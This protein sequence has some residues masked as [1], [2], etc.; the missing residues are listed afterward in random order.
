MCGHLYTQVPI[1][2]VFWPAT[3]EEHL[4]LSR[5]TKGVSAVTH[6]LLSQMQELLLGLLY[7]W[8]RTPDDNCVTSRTLH[9]KVDVDSTTFL[10]DGADQTALCANERVV[11]FGRDWDLHLSYVGLKS[12]TTLRG[13]Y[14]LC[15]E[16]SPQ[17]KNAAPAWGCLKKQDGVLSLG[18]QEGI[19]KP[20]L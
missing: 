13:S 1:K 20:W 3:R 12:N 9:R 18:Q 2:V 5:L 7:I 11:K 8:G 16:K 6:L 14:N 17:E 10:H 4:R 19:G 15:G